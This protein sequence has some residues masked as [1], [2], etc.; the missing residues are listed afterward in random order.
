[1]D[2]WA[3]RDRRIGGR[4]EIDPVDVEWLV[5]EVVTQGLLRRTRSFV[6]RLPGRIVNVS[7]SGAGILG[8][9]HASLREGS[10][11]TIDYDGGL[12]RVWIRRIVDTDLPSRAY[13]GV[14]LEEMHPGLRDAVYGVIG[15]RRPA[16]QTWRRAR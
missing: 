3:V 4:V 15:R 9:R 8:P 13:Y 6:V 12:S 11:V 7:A 2:E 16:E 1:M 5:T 14:E 10:K